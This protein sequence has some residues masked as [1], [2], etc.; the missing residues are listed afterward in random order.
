MKKNKH[1]LTHPTVYKCLSCSTEFET[2]STT[3]SEKSV[4]TEICSQCNTF[5]TGK[6]SNEI[7]TG[8][9]EKFKRRQGEYNKN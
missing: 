8:G 2:V 5:Y 7:K 4:R 9:V 6:L 3:F 1:L